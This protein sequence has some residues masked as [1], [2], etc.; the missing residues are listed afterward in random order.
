M[1]KIN[2]KI[3]FDRNWK[4]T[5]IILVPLKFSL[6][7]KKI[8]NIF[9]KLLKTTDCVVDL[10]CGAG[11]NN[12]FF[13][14]INP[15]IKYIGIDISQEALKKA[16]F[17]NCYKNSVFIQK[18][19][20]KNTLPKNSYSLVY[21]SQLLEHIKNDKTFIKKIYQSLKPSGNLIIST[22]YK[23]KNAIYFY[24]NY[25]GERVLAPD[26][27]NEYTKI[28]TLL[29]LLSKTDF[30]II[31]YDLTLFRYPLIDVFLKPITKIFQNK[32]LNK[33]VNSSFIMFLRYYLVIPI[34]GFYN[35]QIIAKKS[36][37]SR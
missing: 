18:N 15:K 22:V 17:I 32:S 3:Y 14:Q 24:K 10:G 16:K 23:K 12:I 8:R 29:N 20:F 13:H 2:Q 6:T 30:K 35:F 34:F 7:S 31:D 4:N 33:F 27:N 26:H 21:C 1:H 9:I 11:G 36:L 25:L 5:E 28:D 37:R 19:L